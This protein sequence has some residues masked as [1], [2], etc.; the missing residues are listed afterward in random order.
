MRVEVNWG[1]C[2]KRMV[3]LEKV[4]IVVKP[5]ENGVGRKGGRYFF[6][7]WKIKYGVEKGRRRVGARF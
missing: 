1:V 6:V 7:F 5:G 4:E 2:N 3:C